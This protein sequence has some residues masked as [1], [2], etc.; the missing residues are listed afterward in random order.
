[1]VGDFLVSDFAF[2]WPLTLSPPTTSSIALLRSCF[3]ST[4]LTYGIYTYSG[5]LV[6]VVPL[7]DVVICTYTFCVVCY[8]MHVIASSPICNFS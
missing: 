5:S 8:H 6:E 3:V 4:G 1:M 7:H 2:H